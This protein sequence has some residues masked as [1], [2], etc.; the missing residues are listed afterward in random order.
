MAQQQLSPRKYIQTRARTL[1]VYKCLVNADWRESD[2]A[3]ITV[4]RR[5][6]NGNV[7]AGSY[8]VDLLCLGVKDTFFWFNEPESAITDRMPPGMMME[9]DYNLAH[10]IIWAGHDFAADYD[11]EPTKDFALTQMILEEDNDDIP[12]MEIHTGDESGQPRL[13]ANFPG[14]YSREL[15]ILA[16]SAGEGNYSFVSAGADLRGMMGGSSDDDEDDPDFA[17]RLADLPE[18][19]I[20][21]QV[22]SRLNTEDLLDQDAIQQRSVSEQMTLLVERLLRSL[23]N[24]DETLFAEM[25]SGGLTEEDYEMLAD[26]LTLMPGSVAMEI[27][28]E[29]PE[30]NRSEWM[31]E[32]AEEELAGEALIGQVREII[33]RYRDKPLVLMLIADFLIPTRRVHELPEFIEI[34]DEL[35]KD[36]LLARI[37]LA[38]LAADDPE[39]FSRYD[40]PEAKDQPLR[41]LFPESDGFDPFEFHHYLMLRLQLNIN[42]GDLRSAIGAYSGLGELDDWSYSMMG[43][44][45][46]FGK[47]LEDAFTDRVD[48]NGELREKE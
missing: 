31:A 14:Q 2:L 7:T 45:M 3:S 12:L 26:G 34:L 38:R 35:G 11:I 46:A 20:G 6:V 22:A 27:N 25:Q 21:I 1:P 13:V 5:H 10:N 4:M 39:H 16:R 36:Y 23:A 41:K 29:D 37:L 47:M 24:I 33:G 8:L 44:Q 40:L 9:I 42:S 28:P 32:I 48:E 30:Q 15:S 17:L 43:V 18:N 19:S